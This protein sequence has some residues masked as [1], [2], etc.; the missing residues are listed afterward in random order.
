MSSLEISSL[1]VFISKNMTDV[2]PPVSTEMLVFLNAVGF[3]P[4]IH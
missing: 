4:K 3:R 2:R 1:L